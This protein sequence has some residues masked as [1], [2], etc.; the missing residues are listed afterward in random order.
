MSMWRVRRLTAGL[1]LALG[2]GVQAEPAADWNGF[3]LSQLARE[4]CV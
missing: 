3:D 2:L 1:L 4:L